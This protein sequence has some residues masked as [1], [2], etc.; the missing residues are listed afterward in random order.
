MAMLIVKTKR[1]RTRTKIKILQRRPQVIVNNC[2]ENQRVYKILPIASGKKSCSNS[3]KTAANDK[4]IFI[5]TDSITKRI[6]IYKFNQHM[7]KIVIQ[8]L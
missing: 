2:P 5:F 6:P 3:L 8:N 4:D 7:S 1:S